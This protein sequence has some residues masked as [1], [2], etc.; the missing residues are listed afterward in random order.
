MPLQS[1]KDGYIV[2]ASFWF[3]DLSTQHV[4]PVGQT[5]LKVTIGLVLIKV[6]P[7]HTGRMRT[8]IG[9]VSLKVRHHNG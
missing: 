6:S 5:S 4:T 2:I 8:E 7:W 1:G 3:V 9:S